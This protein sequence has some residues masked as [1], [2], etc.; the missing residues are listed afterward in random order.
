[1]ATFCGIADA[2][3]PGHI[4]FSIVDAKTGKPVGFAR[5]ALAGAR[6]S[7]ILYVGRSGRLRLRNIPG[8]TYELS[9]YAPGY[10]Q[11]RTTIEIGDGETTNVE[12]SLAPLG[13]LKVIATVAVTRQPTANISRVGNSGPRAVSASSLYDAATLLPDI[14]SGNNG[15]SVDGL[16]PNA[17]QYH[18]DGVP[19]GTGGNSPVLSQL[20]L[21]LFD[22]VSVNNIGSSSGP[23]LELTAPD[24]TI[25]FSATGLTQM[26]DSGSNNTSVQVRGT[27]GYVGYV[28]RHVSRDDVGALQG[29]IFRDTSGLTYSHDDQ[30]S[31]QGTLLKVRVPMSEYQHVLLEGIS[32]DSFGGGSCSV[33]SGGTPCGYGP[34]NGN[35]SKYE[36][37]VFNYGLNTGRTDIGIGLSQSSATTTND[38]GARF[39]NGL[40]SPFSAASNFKSSALNASIAGPLSDNNELLGEFYDTTQ[41]VHVSQP[42]FNAAFNGGNYVSA[43]LS[44]ELTLG[45]RSRVRLG[46]GYAHANRGHLSMTLVG[47]KTR[48]NDMFSARLSVGSNALPPLQALPVLGNLA[49]PATVSYD[50]RTGRVFANGDGALPED[51]TTSG[52]QLAYRHEHSRFAINISA[53]AQNV[54]NAQ[55]PTLATSPSITAQ[56]LAALNAFYASPGACGVP[57][58][59]QAS[60]VV[61]GSVLNANLT[62]VRSTVSVA[63]RATSRL[64]IA[65]YVQLTSSHYNS[66]TG[67]QPL[68][69]QPNLRSGLLADYHFNDRKTEL[70]S[71][72]GMEGKNNA[73]G[74]GPYALLD[75][76]ISRQLGRGD[77]IVSVT[78]VANAYASR[79]ESSAFATPLANGILPM[80]APFLGTAFHVSYQ[81]RSGSKSPPKRID[82]LAALAEVAQPSTD[83]T[84]INVGELPRVPPKNPYA[85]NTNESSCEPE[86]VAHASAILSA[87]RSIAERAVPGAP[88]RDY[89]LPAPQEKALGVKITVHE[90]PG[91][92]AFTLYFQQPLA[93]G[94]FMGCVSQHFAG[95]DEAAELGLY[96]P[97]VLSAPTSPVEYFDARVGAYTL[98]A[99]L[100][101]PHSVAAR[102]SGG[103]VVDLVSVPV[104][105]PEEPFRLKSTCPFDKRPFAQELLN[106]FSQRFARGG[107]PLTASPYFSIESHP[108]SKATWWSIHFLD[109]PSKAV[110]GECADVAGAL[111][112]DLTSAGVGAEANALNFATRLGL[113]EAI[114]LGP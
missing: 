57:F 14:T 81:I 94:A 1:M 103:A 47:E 43:R 78:N 41:S 54:H 32:L 84:T 110:I 12:V 99:S 4:A 18:I 16:S 67:W 113:Y 62:Q 30:T 69:F 40:S 101:K 35:R 105:T 75:V 39:V 106:E 97:N 45:G 31:G 46:I 6:Y 83:M 17:T 104:R 79:F 112:S 88:S 26:A 61:L 102:G 65:P 49:D 74:I 90:R 25:A 91:F 76:G 53:S 20:G 100:A 66:G 44:D 24:P 55:I 8:G 107:N 64:T 22:A 9:I 33:A 80:A 34:G 58:P 5:V 48:G 108:G 15:L 13:A 21:G 3:S 7:E 73:N 86:T 95:A 27:S 52:V 77:L 111:P 37:A 63:W 29:L 56:Q 11:K 71:L 70:I 36:D 42:G 60:D 92:V 68:L 28:M 10:Q 98:L 72:V 93:E 114:P 51:P 50:C 23:G 38:F 89:R 19:V 96:V 2:A 59:L 109:A 85:P 87:M 82:A